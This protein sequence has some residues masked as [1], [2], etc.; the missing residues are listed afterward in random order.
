MIYGC[1]FFVIE[2]VS[3]VNEKKNSRRSFI[4]LLIDDEEKREKGNMAQN[5]EN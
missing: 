2:M 1:I 5:V 4:N 3:L